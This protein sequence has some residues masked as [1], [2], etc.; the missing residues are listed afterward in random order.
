MRIT[1]YPY[2]LLTNHEKKMDVSSLQKS[3]ESFIINLTERA[4]QR[5]TG[6]ILLASFDKFKSRGNNG[7]E[8]FQHL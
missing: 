2:R 4:C 7:R 6:S 1:N 5:T 8:T 3:E